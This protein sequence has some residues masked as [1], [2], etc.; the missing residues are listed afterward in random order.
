MSIIIPSY[1]YTYIKIEYLK[2]LIMDEVALKALRK[3]EEIQ[4]FINFIRPY[5]PNINIQEYTVEE[6]EKNLY[7]TYIK[8]I[9]KIMVYS[10]ENMRY[11]LRNFLL[12]YEIYNIKQIV[13]GIIVGMSLEER[14][15]NVNFLVERYLN[16]EEFI[17]RLLELYSLEE[18]EYYMRRT[19]YN[20]VIREGLLYFR[21]TNEIFVLEA[22][23][24]RLYYSNL[25]HMRK[26]FQ[27]KERI[28]INLFV[29]Y[30][31]EIYNLKMIY[32]G[33]KNNIDRKLLS[34]FLIDNYLFL[35]SEQL[36]QL[37][38]LEN[39][40]DFVVRIRNFFKNNSE[41]KKIY[42]DSYLNEIHLIWSIENL[43]V[44]YYF[45]KFRLKIDDIDYSTIY[46]ILE[47]IIKKE[48]EI[49]FEILPELVEIIN[50]NFDS[51]KLKEI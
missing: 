3:I 6:I 49:K 36:R 23:L 45:R 5:Y 37:I 28:M 47:L 20:E 18:I 43:Y 31:V 14:K 26:R 35:S 17:N 15:K 21:N 25:V 13:I 41:L 9:G 8:L 11:F 16:N 48:K 50:K 10:P 29:D 22:F 51:L 12:K 19:R 42:N 1:A 40:E 24:D 7:H 39:I 30:V 4:E 32:R 27:K 33:I 2:V 44:K 38:A 34:Q 46:K